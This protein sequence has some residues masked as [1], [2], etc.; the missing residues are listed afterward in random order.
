MILKSSANSAHFQPDRF[1]SAGNCETAPLTIP[2][3]GI[4]PAPQKITEPEVNLDNNVIRAGVKKVAL[5][6]KADHND[7]GAILL[8]CIAALVERSFIYRR[9]TT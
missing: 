5:K 3:W 7:A 4:W 2:G 9:V 6:L 1:P 8:E